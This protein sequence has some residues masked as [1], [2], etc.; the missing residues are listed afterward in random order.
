MEMQL[1][2]EIQRRPFFF[3][4]LNTLKFNKDYFKRLSLSLALF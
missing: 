4:Y 2:F 3:K 1:D